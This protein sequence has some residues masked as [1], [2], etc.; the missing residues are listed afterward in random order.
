VNCE[1][2]CRPPRSPELVH[3]Q[4]AAFDDAL[5]RAVRD[6]LA[7]MLRH[8]DLPSVGMTPFLMA[9]AL[10]DQHKAVSSQHRAPPRR[11]CKLE[12]AGSRQRQ[13]HEPRVLVQLQFGRLKPERQRLACV[14]DGFLLGIPGGR[15][16]GQLGKHR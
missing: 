2:R 10:S 12:N 3:G 9:L 7:A 13:F 6:R 11:R 1:R 5:E 8:N 14:R 15:A 16:A 4:P